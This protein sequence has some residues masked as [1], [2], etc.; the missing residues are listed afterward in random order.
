MGVDVFDWYR[1]MPRF[2]FLSSLEMF[3]FSRSANVS[4]T[5]TKTKRFDNA[6]FN[7]PENMPRS[8][9]MEEAVPVW[10]RY[11]EQARQSIHSYF[12]PAHC[13]C[14]GHK[15]NSNDK[16]LFH[17]MF[18]CQDIDSVRGVSDI[19]LCSNCL[20]D[21]QR[22][23]VLMFNRISLMERAMTST[24]RVCAQCIGEGNGCIA[25]QSADGSPVIEDIEDL[26]DN[27]HV[28]LYAASYYTECYHCPQYSERINAL[29]QAQV[30]PL[31]LKFFE[32]L[33][34]LSN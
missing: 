5:E 34:K 7:I 22:T 33:D 21:T 3:S 13:L 32:I 20:T 25:C 26:P 12:K 23:S 8:S 19:K 17:A 9:V 11:V 6:I 28:D 31:Y 14:C 2:M 16:D 27:V 1:D 15:L 10:K 29:S 30:I 24:M 4:A 18:Q